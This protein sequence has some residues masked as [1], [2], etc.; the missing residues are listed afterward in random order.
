MQVCIVAKP[1]LRVVVVL[2]QHYLAYARLADLSYSNNIPQYDLYRASE[3]CIC[4]F[5]IKLKLLT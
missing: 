4:E 2:F 3:I 5:I 1:T